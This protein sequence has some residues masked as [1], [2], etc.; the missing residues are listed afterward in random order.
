M[1]KCGVFLGAF[2]KIGE[3]VPC[4]VDTRMGISERMIFQESTQMLV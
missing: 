2:Q 1:I 4:A 3:A